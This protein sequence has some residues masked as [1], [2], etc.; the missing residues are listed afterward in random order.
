MKTADRNCPKHFH[1]C[2]GHV[3]VFKT[4]HLEVVETP[5]PKK[6]KMQG[7]DGQTDD[8]ETE[9]DGTPVTSDDDGHE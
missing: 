7:K 8:D 1:D 6:R 5:K 4:T 3:V 2:M 9:S